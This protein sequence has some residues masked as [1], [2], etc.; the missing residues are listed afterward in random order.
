MSG[1]KVAERGN[2]FTAVMVNEA[3]LLDYTFRLAVS[4]IISAPYVVEPKFSETPVK[5]SSDGFG[6]QAATP[7]RFANPVTYFHFP[8]PWR[9][10]VAVNGHYSAA[11][12]RFTGFFQYHGISFRSGKNRADNL[13]AILY[14]R[15]R[16]PTCGR[17]YVGVG[18]ITEHR[19][20][21]GFTP[22]PE[23][24]SAGFYH[25]GLF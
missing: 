15:M 5:E 24:Q 7:E 13:S 14:R 23:Y 20:G 10:A 1:A 11:S 2:L 12:Y 17:S 4:V 16:R 18:S 25:S 8:Q 6:Y 19:F 22:R 9:R 21:I 3:A